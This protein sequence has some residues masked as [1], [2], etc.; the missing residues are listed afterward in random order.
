MIILNSS[1]V[2]QKKKRKELARAAVVEAEV[3][4]EAGVSPK[5]AQRREDRAWQ[6]S[7]RTAQAAKVKELLLQNE[8][9]SEQTVSATVSAID[10][11]AS[12]KAS[13]GVL[14]YNAVAELQQEFIDCTVG[15]AVAAGGASCIFSNKKK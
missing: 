4:A 14:S 9:R 10:A 1:S 15:A 5:E 13:R 8:Q 11:A 6:N 7:Q 2:M 3:K 12:S